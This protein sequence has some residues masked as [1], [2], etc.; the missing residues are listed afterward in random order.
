MA[1]SKSIIIY[2]SEDGRA[3][4][5]VPI[6]AETVW[7]SQK[8]MALLFDCSVDNIALHLK[9]IFSE[10]ELDAKATSEDSTVVQKEGARN[11]KRPL[12]LF[13][14]NAIISVGYRVN[15]IRGTQFRIW[16]TQKLREYMV[17]GFVLDDER[18]ANGRKYGYFDELLE[19]VRAIRASER[20]FYQKITD[21]Y[22]TS[23]DY[24][25]NAA[26]TQEFF[27]TVQNKMHFAIHG[28]TAAEIIAL[29]A[30]AKKPHM[31]LTSFKGKSLRESDIIIAKNYLNED[32]LKNL[33]LI[34]D[35]YLSF[36][37]LQA[38][39]KKAMTMQDWIAKLDSF[40]RL[41]E[42]EILDNA[43]KISKAVADEKAH[44]EFK[45]FKKQEDRN[46]ISDFD[47]S[48]KKYLKPPEKK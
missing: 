29:R 21:I 42:R 5:E 11:V 39:S 19:R 30:D 23:I 13:N 18:L 35:A 15:S 47:R 10:G 46:Y 14:L 38:K 41:S 17:K 20:N 31:G 40:L 28:H 34:V 32:E 26:L 44:N 8:Q 27:A 9:N 36:A 25:Q 43:G 22:A 24:N 45:K 3:K 2:Q 7:L 6:D 48:V 12:K 1:E 4:L 16:A 37:E 33:N